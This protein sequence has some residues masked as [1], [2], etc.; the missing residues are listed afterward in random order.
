MDVVNPA[1]QAELDKAYSARGP[2]GDKFEKEYLPGFTT[3][4]QAARAKLPCRTDIHYGP[5]RDEVC[6]VFPAAR[7]GAPLMCFL[8]GGYWRMLTKDEN[9][10]VATALQP[11][12]ATVMVNTYSL[13]PNVH[14]DVIVQQCRAFIAWAWRNAGFYNADPR[15]IYISG[16]SAGGQLVGMMLA[17]DWERDYGLPN[18]IIKGAV[19]ISGIFDMKPMSRAFTNEWLQIGPAAIERNSPLRL[20]PKVKCPT[21][22]AVGGAEVPGFLSN[23]AA[24]AAYMKS[25]GQPVEIVDLPGMDHFGAWNEIMNPRAPLTKAVMKMMGL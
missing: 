9:S 4:S 15:R 16:H 17:T 2:I 24:Y 12:G 20:E 3:Y 11:A 21:I 14:I 10:Y 7:P 8:H 13:A 18:D 6:D 22:V 25:K 5:H 1:D 19:A 23:S